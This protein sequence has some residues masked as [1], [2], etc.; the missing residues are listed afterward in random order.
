[1]DEYAEG[2]F[3]HSWLIGSLGLTRV[4]QGHPSPSCDLSHQAVLTS[5]G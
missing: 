4:W 1:L 5:C 3:R 2:S